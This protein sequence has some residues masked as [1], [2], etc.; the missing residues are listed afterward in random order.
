[1]IF[2]IYCIYGKL[3]HDIN[4]AIGSLLLIISAFFHASWNAF[5]KKADD[6][7]AFLLGMTLI[8]VVITAVMIS[9]SSHSLYD[10]HGKILLYTLASGVFEGLYMVTL[11][12]A[13]SL[14]SLGKTYAI[15]RGGAMVFVW[16]ISLSLLG[17]APIP[18]HIFGASC[19]LAGMIIL[20]RTDKKETSDKKISIWPFLAAFCIAGYH[21]CYHQALKENNDPK[22]LFIISMIISSLI[23]MTFMAKDLKSRIQTIFKNSFK[24]VLLTAFLSTASFVIFLYALQISE[25]GYAI[26]LRNSSIFFA[27]IFSYLLKESLSKIQIIAASAIGIGTILL[28]FY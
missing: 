13:L 23:L 20:S 17:E 18:I 24:S 15:M 14:G 4:M 5:T 19:V 16:A 21:I 6:K 1:M 10:L 22:T 28:S 11:S 9:L 2:N 3:A 25:P 26:S 7:Q 12:K 27:L 8:S